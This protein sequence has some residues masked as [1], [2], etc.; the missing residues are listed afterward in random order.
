MSSNY[1]IEQRSAFMG[2]DRDAREALRG[3]R[4]VIQAEIGSALDAFYAKVRATPETRAFFGDDKHM[5]SASRR[6]AGHWDVIAQADFSDTYVRA[7][8]AIGQTHARI[9]LEPRWYIGGYAVVSDRLL[10]GA[11]RSLWPSKMFRK[12]QDK[13]SE[14]VTALMKAVLLDMDFAISIYLETIE[15]ERRQLESARAAAEQS[16]AQAV[17]ALGAALDRLARGDLTGPDGRRGLAS[18]PEAQG[19]FQ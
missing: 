8:R 19:R 11:I 12:G 16:Q 7:V 3:L 18:V 4:P 9:G 14:A 6:Q 2:L 17:S 5:E 1:A 13:M 10:R 15:D